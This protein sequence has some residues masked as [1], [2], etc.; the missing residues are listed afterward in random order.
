MSD[1]ICP[2]EIKTDKYTFKYSTAGGEKTRIE[3]DDGGTLDLNWICRIDNKTGESTAI[4]KDALFGLAADDN[5]VYYASWKLSDGDIK[6]VNYIRTDYNGDNKQI[7]YTDSYTPY[8]SGVGNPPNFLLTAHAL[9]VYKFNLVEISLD[10]FEK[11]VLVESVQ[12]HTGE[13]EWMNLDFVYDDTF[14][15]SVECNGIC[16]T[17]NCYMLTPIKTGYLCF[18]PD[19]E[20]CPDTF[21]LLLDENDKEAKKAMPTFT[22][23]S[24]GQKAELTSEG[25]HIY[26]Y[27]SNTESFPGCWY[28]FDDDKLQLMKSGKTVEIRIQS[29]IYCFPTWHIKILTMSR[30]SIS[31][32]LRM[33]CIRA[34]APP[35]IASKT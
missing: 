13:A 7:L 11:T 3:C 22:N 26:P 32:I 34:T 6:G 35:I 31:K 27:S 5:Y 20:A 18:A 33:I 10:T 15:F 25:I 17:D 9:Y 21:R 12:D 8:G 24:L 30:G 29:S 23:T 4:I 28:R 2:S 16:N 1:R 19:V 14:Y